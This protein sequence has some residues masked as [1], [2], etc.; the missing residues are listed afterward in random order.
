M[1]RESY[2]SKEKEFRREDVISSDIVSPMRMKSI[3]GSKYFITFLDSKTQHQWVYFLK[4]RETEEVTT[5]TK[6][7]LNYFENHVRKLQYYRTDQGVELIS[8]LFN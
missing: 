3:G 6:N 2:N 8:D 5:V 1:K 4:M 7:F